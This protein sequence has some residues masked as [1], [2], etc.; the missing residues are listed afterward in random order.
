MTSLMVT[1]PSWF[2]SWFD[3]VCAAM[4]VAVRSVVDDD[5]VVEVAAEG[6]VVAS[7]AGEC[8]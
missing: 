1:L 3:G 2:D 6:D 5:V 8:Q 4:S 7:S